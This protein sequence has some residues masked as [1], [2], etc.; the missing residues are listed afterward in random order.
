[1]N[2]GFP[3]AG[4]IPY[5][6]TTINMYVDKQQNDSFGWNPSRGHKMYAY[7]QRAIQTGCFNTILSSLTGLTPL[8]VINTQ[9][10]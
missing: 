9:N 8:T 7:T 6:G 3:S 10:N 1:M 4:L 2:S 5:G